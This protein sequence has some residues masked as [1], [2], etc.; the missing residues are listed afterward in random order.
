MPF[1]QQIASSKSFQNLEDRDKR[2]CRL[3]I[4]EVIRHHGQIDFILKKFLKQGIPRS[5]INF[6]NILRMGVAELLFI[7]STKYAAINDAVELVKLKVSQAKTGVVNAVLRR[8]DKESEVLIIQTSNSHNFPKWLLDDWKKNWGE[9]IVKSII[10]TVMKEPYL[11][12][13]VFGD[14]KQ[15]ESILMGTYLCGKTIR[16]ISAGDPTS[17]PEYHPKKI[18]YAWWIQD[19]SATI[20][21]QL[22]IKKDVEKIIDLCAAPGGK[23]AQLAAYGKEVVA[24][25]ISLRRMKTLNNNLNRIGLKVEQVINDATT[26]KPKFIP[27]AI[28]IDAPCTATGT[29]RRHPDILINRSKSMMEDL[30]II[31]KTLLK[32]SLSWIKKEGIIV[33]AVCSLQKN[34]GE[35]QINLFLIE[36]KNVIIDPIQPKEVIKFEGAICSEG[37]MRIF[38]HCLNQEGGNDGFFVCRLKRID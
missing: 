14:P 5:H 6:H 22:L 16:K 34:E 17:I 11:D 28:L 7:K 20:P 9:A 19:V 24:V 12:I 26:W 21:A 35:D 1:E 37:W 3:L 25:D 30:L 33:Y 4:T 8:I 31:Q 18:D 13:T 15:M 23:S 29:I 2:F 32:R 27:N 38:P 36:N 10:D